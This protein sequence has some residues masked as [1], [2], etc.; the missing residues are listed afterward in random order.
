MR[1]RHI[2][3]AG[4]FN[5]DALG[6]RIDRDSGDYFGNDPNFEDVYTVNDENEYTA[7]QNNN[8]PPA[9]TFNPVYDNNGNMELFPVGAGAWRPGRFAFDGRRGV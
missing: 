6:N 3:G 2:G 7:I 1:A 9:G 4:T 8:P 5:L